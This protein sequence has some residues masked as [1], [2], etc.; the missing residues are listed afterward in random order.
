MVGFA[1]EAQGFDGNGS[2]IRTG[3]AAATYS[4]K[5]GKLESD[6]PPRRQRE[7]RRYGNARSSRR[8]PPYELDAPVLP[9]AAAGR[10]RTA[11]GPG[12][13]ASKN[14]K[15]N[16]NG[17]R[18]PSA[19]RRPTTTSPRDGGDAVRHAIQKHMRDFIAIIVL[20][21]IAG[22]VGGYILA[23]QRFYLPGWVP[24]VGTDFF[25]LKGEFAPR[26][27]SRPARARR[28]TSPACR[29]GEIKKVELETAARS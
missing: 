18:R 29:S 8:A 20:V 11:G 12:A 19:R 16:L 27:R 4:I 5:T 13:A 23:H 22:F 17:R 9:P 1:G 2:Y 15:P 6:G 26:S 10:Q 21:L 24:V 14:A 28:S 7:P 3:P 25:E